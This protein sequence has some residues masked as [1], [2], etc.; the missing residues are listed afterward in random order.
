[1]RH[2]FLI[3]FLFLF[4][5][6]N[7][8]WTHDSVKLINFVYT[9]P[10]HSSVFV[11]STNFPRASSMKRPTSTASRAAQTIRRERRW[12]RRTCHQR[13]AKALSFLLVASISSTTRTFL[14]WCVIFLSAHVVVVVSEKLKKFFFFLLFHFLRR[15][16][17]APEYA[18]LSSQE[19]L[20]FRYHTRKRWLL[21]CASSRQCLLFSPSLKIQ[22]QRRRRN[23]EARKTLPS[24]TFDTINS[25]SV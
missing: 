17:L 7:V 15:F 24:G 1:M 5:T 14:R 21:A 22:K 18:C 12:T 6:F 16:S 8:S 10:F 23:G 13:R 25:F 4:P 19:V 9:I 3:I 2:K 20:I 11:S